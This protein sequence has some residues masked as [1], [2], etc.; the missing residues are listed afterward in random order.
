MSYS[1]SE[2]ITQGVTTIKASH[3]TE[4]HTNINSERIAR[5]LGA[6]SWTQTPTTGQ[7]HLNVDMTEMRTALD[8]AHTENY[9]H[10]VVTHYST[11]NPTYNATVRTCPSNYYVYNTYYN[12]CSYHCST[13]YSTY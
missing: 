2:T 10:T 1:W 13:Y 8:Q 7:K 11:H 6:Y 4:L 5:G 3:V 12:T 9:C